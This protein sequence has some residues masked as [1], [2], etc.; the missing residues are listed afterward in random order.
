LNLL[1][2]YFSVHKFLNREK[3]TFALL[4]AL[5]Y[6]KDWWETFCEQKETEET[7]L[8][9]VTTT[10]ESFRDAIKEQYYPIISYD[11]VYTK[12]TTLRQERDQ[13]VPDFTNI[14]HA[15]HTK[16]GIKDSERHLVLKYRSALH[17]YIHTKMEFLDISSL[18]AAY[19]YA[20][21]I[22]HKLKQKT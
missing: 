15:L 12:W 4:K 5:P 21:K 3:I 14:F 22:K 20:V 6:V 1:E 10:W 18:G 17:I 13:A 2:G 9:S 16:L 11:K 7:S 19:R 8:F